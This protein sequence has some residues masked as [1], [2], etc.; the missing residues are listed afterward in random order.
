MQDLTPVEAIAPVELLERHADEVLEVWSEASGTAPGGPR[1][2]DRIREILPRHAGRAGFRF[3]AAREDGV[4]AGFVYGYL[5]GPGQWWH[6]IVAAKLGDEG[7]GRWLAPGHFELVELHVRPRFQG[8]GIGGRLH[9]RVLEGL[10]GP[11]AVLSTQV[12][13]ERALRLYRG[14]RW[15]VIVPELRFSSGG[16]PF[17]V[18]GLDLL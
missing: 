3:L 16:E 1:A 6:D 17:C 8:R 9:D 2:R 18:M 14:R 7:L 11:T 4:L 15:Q 10:T 13:N 5:G 12:D